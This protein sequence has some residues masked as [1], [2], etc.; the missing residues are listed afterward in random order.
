MKQLTKRDLDE[1]LAVRGSSILDL[2]M[3]ELEDM[4]LSRYD[5]SNIDFSLSA[6]R[7]VDFTGADFT[8]SNVSNTLFLDTKL[9]SACFKNANL[10]CAVLRY[11]NLEDADLRGADLF[12]ASLE[13]TN[14]KGVLTDYE[15]KWFDLYC[16]KEGAFIAYKKC[17]YDRIVMLLI[18]ADARRSSATMPTCRCDKAKVLT[19]TSFDEK[20][21]YT[22]AWSLVDENFVYRVGE[23]VYEP[24]FNE[25]RFMDSTRGIH[26]WMTRD[27]A[28][29]Y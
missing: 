4:D 10:K 7:D 8:G 3:T 9:K 13:G 29:K 14:V 11:N 12:S 20:T 6:F 2:K 1:V 17:V 19:I 5:L 15:T 18:P 23:W 16:P 28:M 22:E 21:S 25:D 27:E 24:E 26:F